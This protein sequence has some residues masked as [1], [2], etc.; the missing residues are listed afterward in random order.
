MVKNGLLTA[1][2][3]FAGLVTTTQAAS[4][5]TLSDQIGFE[6]ASVIGFGWLILLLVLGVAIILPMMRR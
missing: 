2:A 6:A 4:A 3:G 1:L 5:Q